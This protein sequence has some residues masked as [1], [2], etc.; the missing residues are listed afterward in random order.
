MARKLRFSAVWHEMRHTARMMNLL[1]ALAIMTCPVLAASGAWAQ[2]P[3]T[4]PSVHLIWMGGN[5]CPPCVAWRQTELPKLQAS[6]EFG[7]IRFSYV[8]K[9]IKSPVPPSLLL[10]SEVKPYK[11][12]L[13]FASSGRHGSPQAALM[14]SG[15]VYDYFHNARTA[16]DIER[17][18]SAIRTGGPYPFQRCIK[19]SRQWG[20]CEVPG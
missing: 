3:T 15:E 19:A 6:S 18:L 4:P 1:R 5:D 16:E 17:M 10:P 9:T 13:D 7:A 12:K 14:V 20:Q 2:G 8:V 11:D